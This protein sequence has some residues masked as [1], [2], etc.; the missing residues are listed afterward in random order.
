MSLNQRISPNLSEEGSHQQARVFNQ[1]GF[2]LIELNIVLLILAIMISFAVPAF[3][4]W[5]VQ[6]GLNNATVVL[7]HKLKQARSL[8][9]AESRSVT[10]N[11]AATEITYDVYSVGCSKCKNQ[12]IDF[13]TYSS[14]L[15]MVSTAGDSSLEFKS[16][17]Q[18]NNSAHKLSIGADYKCITV[19]AIGRAYIGVTATCTGL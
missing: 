5:R 15:T 12:T 6:A 18:G 2:N 4:E 11:I 14:D 16:N 8:A 10:V 3:Q 7:F 9:V 19:N 1:A 17:G 13:S